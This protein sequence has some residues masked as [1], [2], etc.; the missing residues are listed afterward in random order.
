MRSEVCCFSAPLVLSSRQI[1]IEWGDGA[2]SR[3]HF[4][5]LRQQFFHPAIGRSD[6]HPEEGFR[7]PDDPQTLKVRACCIDNNKLVVTWDNDG[8]V[9]CHDL[10]WLRA[11]AYDTML[12]EARKLTCVPWVGA[13]AKQFMWHSWE[14][15]L[16]QDQALWALYTSL[17]DLGFARLNGA[18]IKAGMVGQLGVKFGPLRAG[19]A[20]E[21]YDI[22]I[23]PAVDD[24]QYADCGALTST[25]TAL[26]TDEPWRYGPPGVTF[27][28]GYR[29]DHSGGGASILV[30]GLL[31]AERLRE[32]D[33]SSFS[34][35]TT[36]P[37][38]LSSSH[39]PQQ[40]FVATS[41]LIATD[42]DGDIIGVRFNDQALVSQDLPEHLIEPAYRA[43]PAF[44]AELYAD[45][46]AYEHLLLPGE[47][48]I[49]DNHRV[50]H[51][52]R[53]TDERGAIGRVQGCTV[54]RE[55]FHNQLRCLAESLG[56]WEDAQMILPNGALG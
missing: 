40:R 33:P 29:C 6:Q 42:Q 16:W 32:N 28:F 1:E 52:H 11:N 34:F 30:D 10:G 45:D 20:G 12:R 5:W 53:G 23:D 25:R 14:A 27:H 22:L 38:R 48:H 41:H 2:T 49:F 35:L 21:V 4:V 19:E 44:A 51:A 18:P 50:L 7:L 31:A 54:D 3:F 46:L 39:H 15:V 13:Q 8:V 37:L 55:E 47:I 36:V 24:A 17:R 26:C 43:I 56:Y 9:T